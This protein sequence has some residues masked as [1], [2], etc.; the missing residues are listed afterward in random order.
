MEPCDRTCSLTSNYTSWLTG[1]IG[2][3]GSSFFPR[4]P[5]S[6]GLTSL[7]LHYEHFSEAMNKVWPTHTVLP[8]GCNTGILPLC[9]CSGTVILTLTLTLTVTPQWQK[10]TSVLW[11]AQHGHSFNAVTSSMWQ[12]VG[13]ANLSGQRLDVY[14]TSTHGVALVRI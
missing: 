7:C 2:L 8:I 12:P 4:Q 5:R 13:S 11:S 9:P 10:L 3:V 14:H 1:Y 6:S